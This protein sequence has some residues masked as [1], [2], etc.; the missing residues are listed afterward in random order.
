MND[1][2]NNNASAK[3]ESQEKKVGQLTEPQRLHPERRPT[4]Y[5][6]SDWPSK[7]SRNR[8]KD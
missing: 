5:D 2:S 4:G 8:R 7:N 1:R 6:N 3:E